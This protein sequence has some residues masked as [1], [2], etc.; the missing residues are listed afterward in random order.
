VYEELDVQIAQAKAHMS[1]LEQLRASLAPA[2]ERLTAETHR[3]QGIENC[4]AE[5]ELDIQSLESFT[6]QSLLDSLLWRKEGKLSHLREQL[7]ELTPQYQSGE[8][9]VLELDAAVRQIEGEI[10]GLGRAEEMYKN[11][12]DEKHDRIMTAGGVTAEELEETSAQINA[13]KNERQALRKCLHVAKSLVERLQSKSRALGRAKGKRMHHGAVGAL[14][15]VAVN[16]VHRKA[17]DPVVRRAREGLA[18]FARCIANLTV[19]PESERDGELV[20]IGA[21]L[22][23]STGELN[24]ESSAASGLLDLIHQAIGLVQSKLDEVEPSLAALE[25]RRLQLIETA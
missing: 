23:Q 10:N 6:L 21:V 14:A 11:L 20:R 13:G 4:M 18:E 12:C 8:S 9:A 7:A 22:G 5:V 1:R 15:A 16:A 25:A 19:T 2:R 17:A 3:V 24:V